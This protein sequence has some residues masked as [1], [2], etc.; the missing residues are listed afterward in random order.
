MDIITQYGWQLLT[1]LALLVMSAFFSGSE[2]ALF[3]LTRR[4][5]QSL[6]KSAA[7]RAAIRLLDRPN[8][9]LTVLLL[10]NMLVN[11]GFSVT[12]STVILNL[13]AAGA[14]GLTIGIVSITPLLAL[15]LA[16]EVTPKMLAYSTSRTWATTAAI[17]LAIMTRIL[18]PVI[19]TFDTIVISPL[20]RILTP[21][22]HHN[23][24][25]SSEELS[26]LMELSTRHDN[27]PEDM[28][29]MLLEIVEL[30]D[31]K[32]CDIMVPR[33]DIISCD[34][35]DK[36][37]DV[38]AMFMQTGLKKLPVHDGEE[39][40][41]TGR[42]N[43][44]DLLLRPRTPLRE[45][46]RP[47][48]FIPE[49]AS[50]DQALMQFRVKKSQMAIVVD[51]YGTTAGLVTI[52]DIIEEIVGDIRKR[53]EEHQPPEVQKCGSDEYI[54]S[55]NLAIHDWAGAFGVEENVGRRI[56]TLSG[57]VA[58]ILG[59]IPQVGDVAKWKN[60]T[61][62]VESVKGKRIHSMRLHRGGTSQ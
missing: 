34:I 35:E 53:H 15:I 13:S 52:E 31:L 11:V 59:R 47:V 58:S 41:I 24:D 12:A 32:V 16:G 45:L 38:I 2:T 10:S 29:R 50:L 30:T 27:I 46:L 48:I 20:S 62:V 25:I 28:G 39:A 21:V 1:M 6:E 19:H 36:A 22:A 61:I 44:R 23:Q 8:S 42:I 54:V 18:S 26:A 33:V 40:N 4:D 3:N 57:L 60:L 37:E 51:E 43:A 49:L 7:G 56:H 17:P 5:L 55:G 9:L 14:S